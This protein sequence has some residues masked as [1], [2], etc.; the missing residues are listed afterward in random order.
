MET[1]EYIFAAVIIVAILIA[2]SFLTSIT[3]Q[4][5]RST[6]E[7]DQL[8]MAA[9]KILIE[10]L[11]NPG[12]PPN[13][14]KNIAIG[15]EDLSSLG[16]AVYTEFTRSAYVL[17][18]DKVQRL[19]RDLPEQLYVPPSKLL[20]LLNIGFEYDIKI[21][22][23]PALNVNISHSNSNKISVRVS[24]EQGM[25]AVNANV[26]AKI[27][28]LINGKIVSSEGSSSTGSTGDC[29]IS[30]Q[31]STPA[32]LIVAV[33]HHGVQV[34]KAEYMG[35]PYIG[36]LIGNFLLVNPSINVAGDKTYQVSAVKFSNGSL[37]L[38]NVDCR[39]EFRGDFSSRFGYKVYDMSFEE[40]YLVAV[41]TLAED[42]G[43]IAACKV[44]PNSYGSA[45]GD[46]YPPLAYM[47]ER[48]VKI[49]LSAY[50]FRLRVWK[51][52]W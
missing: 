10:I 14:G 17:D 20:K 9:Q 36:Y 5:Y 44:V 16:L 51:T 34:V 46:V 25:P 30:L 27:F 43:L 21:E 32:L 33:D 26:T 15:A 11:L 50:T 6:S 29:V 39:L 23:I 40:P 22:F 37:K 45:A 31:H 52:S 24:S 42:G 38:I 8:K 12:N 28:Y 47:L 3:P 13:W 48:S 18:P 49:G 35:S 7:I 2:A 41:I 4:L 19:S 1:Y